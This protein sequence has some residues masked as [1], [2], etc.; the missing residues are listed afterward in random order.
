MD[1]DA[2]VVG[3]GLTAA[4]IVQAHA[5]S[6]AR[7]T[8]VTRAALRERDLD[9]E[10]PWLGPNLRRFHAARDA[11]ARLSMARRARGG[12]SI[13]PAEHQRL[14]ELMA[15]GHVTHLNAHVEGV[16]R[17]ANQWQLAIHH[18]GSSRSIPAGRVVCATGSRSQARFE[19]LLA[20]CRRDRPARRV[21]G[22][23][24]LDRDL[25]WPGTSI[26]LMGPLAV[27]G[28]GP[29]SRTIIGARIA[30]ERLLESWGYGTTRQ[31]PGPV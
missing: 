28:V 23:P 10:A 20:H 29:A 21:N 24:V 17:S 27:I 5:D 22:M 16:R 30:A 3:G 19:P 4:Q 14:G 13:P 6:G 2:V 8:W 25:A 26:H 18:R 9:V 31:Y 7:V 11:G 12:G 15:S 1:G